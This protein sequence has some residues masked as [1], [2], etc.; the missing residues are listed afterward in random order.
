MTRRETAFDEVFDSQATFRALLDCMARPG[1]VGELPRADYQAAP[2]AFCSPALSILKTLVDHR[3]TFSVAGASGRADWIEYLRL[4][5]SAP[6][7]GPDAA[8]YVLFEGSMYHNDFSRLKLGSLEFPESSATAILSVAALSGRRS[9]GSP[10]AGTDAP[11]CDL[12]LTGPGVRDR[13]N[14]AVR[15]FDPRYVEA[16][17]RANQLF[18]MGIDLLLV[19]A[20]GC[21]AGLPRTSR[22]EVV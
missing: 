4:N 7:Q 13:E 2:H 3:V 17:A 19:D 20:N 10:S 1:T 22:V 8:D 16:R 14:L 6:F 5:L 12:S 18:P 9:A 11:S 15:G 21:V